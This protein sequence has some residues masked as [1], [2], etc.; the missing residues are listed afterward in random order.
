[1]LQLVKL[2]AHYGDLH[3]LKEIS[4]TIKEGE[5][6]SIIGANGAGKTTTVNVISGLLQRTSGEVHFLGERIDHLQPHRI[7]EKGLIQV[8]EGRQLFPAMTV[9]ENLEL[10]SYLK[11]ARAQTSPNLQRVFELF[12]F[13]RERKSQL[14]GSLSGGEQQMLAVSRGLMASPILLMLDEPSLGLAPL[15]V[16]SIFKT[17]QEINA[18]GTSILL[19]DQNVFYALTSSHRGFVMETGQIIMEGESKELLTN[20]HVKKAYL[21]I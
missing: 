9:L 5:A 15:I 11:R 6:V 20:E 1:M 17:V 19:L 8:P 12:P 3:V 7:V 14:A 16:R 10:G 18:S 21:G 2:H 13:L 4:L